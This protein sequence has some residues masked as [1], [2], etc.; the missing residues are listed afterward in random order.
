MTEF[1][2]F[3][4]ILIVKGF[5]LLYCS[6]FAGPVGEKCD[7]CQCDGSDGRVVCELPKCP[8]NKIKCVDPVKGDDCCYHCPNGK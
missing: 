5:L 3:T 1:L 6:L 7:G 4:F 2:L 8:N